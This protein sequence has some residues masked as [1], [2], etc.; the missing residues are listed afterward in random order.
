MSE[1]PTPIATLSLD[2]LNLL[3]SYDVVNLLFTLTSPRLKSRRITS[4]MWR[5]LT[6]GPNDSTV[7]RSVVAHCHDDVL[8]RL[9]VSNLQLLIE[10]HRVESRVAISE[11]LSDKYST[12]EIIILAVVYGD[13]ELLKYIWTRTGGDLVDEMRNSSDTVALMID[14][15]TGI[16]SQRPKID[17]NWIDKYR[18]HLKL[19]RCDLV[20]TAARHGHLHVL[21][22]MRGIDAPS[23][24]PVTPRCYWDESTPFE[25]AKEGNLPLLKWLRDESIHGIDGVCPWD[26]GTFT[27][28]VSSVNRPMIEWLFNN[29][30]PWGTPTC[31]K[32]A[33]CDDFEILKWLRNV[34]IHGVDGVCPWDESVYLELSGVYAR[35]SSDK[36]SGS[37]DKLEWVYQNGLILDEWT[38]NEIE[39]WGM[40]Y[41]VEWLHQLP[42]P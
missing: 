16:S 35:R 9:R 28:A 5:W 39:D 22:W 34:S 37:T 23:D 11:S 33:A 10:Y 8:S 21:M 17:S 29:G 36:A 25:A 40:P 2:V 32:A 31:E 3:T 30:C 7:E 18:L 24:T 15:Q 20:A 14:D 26:E 6:A 41:A 27:N 13:L 12:I 1:L 42:P 38:R 19:W 4:D